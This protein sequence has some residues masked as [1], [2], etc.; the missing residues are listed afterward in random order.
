MTD[1][2]KKPTWAYLQ[3]VPWIPQASDPT[4]LVS[5]GNLCRGT[6][7]TK[8]NSEIYQVT[9]ENFWFWIFLEEI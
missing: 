9:T 5:P 1:N 4:H 3:T 2:M 7:A 8:K 6:A